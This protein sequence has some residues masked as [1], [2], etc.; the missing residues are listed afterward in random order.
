MATYSDNC[1]RTLTRLQLDFA[2]AE[3]AI[4]ILKATVD[5]EMA[6]VMRDPTVPLPST[7]F[8]DD[9]LAYIQD[10]RADVLPMFRRHVRE[11]EA[12]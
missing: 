5:H 7:D 6:H 2:M 9:A 4:G 10:L 8:L 11:E 3:Q 12:A 1:A